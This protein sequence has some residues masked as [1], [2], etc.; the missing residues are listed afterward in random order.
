MKNLFRSFKKTTDDEL[1][2]LWKDAIFVFDTNVLHSVYRYKSSTCEDVLKLMEQL[3]DRVWIPYHVALEFHRNR[4]SVISA[5]HRRFDETRTAIENAINSLQKKLTDL[6]LEKRHS[7][8]DPKEL[9]DGIH[10]LREN[11]LVNLNV[12]EK[13]CLKVDSDDPLL[14]RLEGIFDKRIGPKPNN[15]ESINEIIKEGKERYKS[16]IPPGYKDSV[17]ESEPDN[18]Y[19]YA[20]IT[21][22]RQF[23]DLFVWK[24]LIQYIKTEK[25]KNVIFV[26]D[27]N[28]EDWWQIT[29]GK[30]TGFRYELIDEIISQT[31]LDNFKA[32]SLGGF[33]SDAKLYEMNNVSEDTIEE[34]NLSAENEVSKTSKNMFE[35]YQNES[36]SDEDNYNEIFF[37]GMNLDHKINELESS[38]ITSSNYENLKIK[39]IDIY[40]KIQYLKDC[41]INIKN[42]INILNELNHSISDNSQPKTPLPYGELVRIRNSLIR[43][44][45]ILNYLDEKISS[46][47]NNT[48]VE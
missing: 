27:D 47:D 48:I 21:Y 6:Q 40:D 9:I 16:K 34:V 5:Q 31:E 18:V 17:K 11:Y 30:T 36:G 37:S 42:K 25:I 14:S 12:Q 13:D 24:Q 43:H 44:E 23:G 2:T 29:Q 7:I 39:R 45:K 28:K 33:L 38:K 3:Q 1:K 19:S 41:M 22:E 26:T 46:M 15:S 10:N 4:L 20:G 32:Y 35:I 8:I